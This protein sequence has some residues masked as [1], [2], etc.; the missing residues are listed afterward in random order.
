[1]PQLVV[2]GPVGLGK[3]LLM[4]MFLRIVV[5]AVAT[6]SPSVATASVSFKPAR[7]PLATTWRSPVLSAHGAESPIFEPGIASGRLSCVGLGS[8][9]VVGSRRVLHTGATLVRPPAGALASALGPHRV[10]W[11]RC[12]LGLCAGPR[13]RLIGQA[14]EEV[15]FALVSFS[16]EC[17]A[18]AGGRTGARFTLIPCAGG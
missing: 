8:S 4:A 2:S 16:A 12:R 18:G 15:D 11:P 3:A 14:P 1:M 13:E 17:R 6:E 9:R 7:G 5:G 10:S